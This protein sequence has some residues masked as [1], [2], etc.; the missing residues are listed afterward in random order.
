LALSEMT[1]Q[2]LAVFIDYSNKAYR[3]GLDMNILILSGSPR[4][5]GNTNLLVDAF[6]KGASQKHQVEVCLLKSFVL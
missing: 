6:V 2:S 3:S 1:W 5:G 4:K